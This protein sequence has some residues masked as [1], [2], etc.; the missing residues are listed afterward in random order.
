MQKCELRSPVSSS[1]QIRHPTFAPVLGELDQLFDDLHRRN[2]AVV[3]SVEGRGKCECRSANFEVQSIRHSKFF[4]RHLH[5]PH[6]ANDHDLEKVLGVLEAV[7]QF[8]PGIFAADVLLPLGAVFRAAGQAKCECRSPKS[9]VRSVRHSKLLIRHSPRRLQALLKM[10]HQ[11]GGHECDAFRIAHQRRGKCEC[12]SAK[13]EVPSVRHSAFVIRH[14]PIRGLV[15]DGALDVV[16]GNVI[17]E[18]GPRV[19]VRLLDGRAGQAKSERRSANCEVQS[20]RHSKF[21]IRHFPSA[22]G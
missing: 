22:F 14:F 8:A 16:D 21:N 17:A 19:R 11:I 20:V 1:F 15:G 2:G 9:E 13:S 7:R 12:R 4:V 3:V 10:R 5:R 6:V 18:D